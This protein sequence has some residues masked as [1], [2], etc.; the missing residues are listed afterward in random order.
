MLSN[1]LIK[2]YLS[3]DLKSMVIDT[4]DCVDSTNDIA[5]ELGKN[6]I[7]QALV[8]ASKQTK[9]RG[10]RGRVFFSPSGS[11]IYMSIL[12][13]PNYSA[14]IIPLLTTAAAVAVSEAIQTVTN[15]KT[16]IKWINDL[17]IDYKK[18]CG[19]LCESA[20]SDSGN[21]N[22]VVVGIGINIKDPEEGFPAE[23]SDIAASLFGNEAPSEETVCKL[24]AEITNN[25][26][27][28]S[29][30]LTE[31]TY[32][33]KYRKLLFVLGKEVTV[34]SPVESYSAIPIDIDDDA[35]LIIKTM[36]GTIKAISAGEISL[37]IK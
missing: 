14:D 17:Y 27:K 33:D 11:G 12:L 13:R 25:I 7:K 32:L 8:I 5:K 10:R 20:F 30:M 23:I 36:D 28:Y 37:K 22:F 19:I 18:V 35:H 15:I 1:N 4:Y 16:S 3:N 34:I 2:Q 29:N 21:L 9:G 31:R 24:C 26:F 6:D